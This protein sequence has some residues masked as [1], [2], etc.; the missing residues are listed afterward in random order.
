MVVE[1]EKRRNGMP[2]TL[3]LRV[4]LQPFLSTNK[5]SPAPD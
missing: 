2:D 4:C 3:R 5:F 1:K